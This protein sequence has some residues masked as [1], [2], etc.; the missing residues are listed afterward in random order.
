MRTVFREKS[1]EENHQKRKEKDRMSLSLQPYWLSIPSTN[2]GYGKPPEVKRSDKA[3]IPVEATWW[4]SATVVRWPRIKIS[5][6]K[7]REWNLVD[8]P[9]PE[10]QGV[11][12]PNFMCRFLTIF[13]NNLRIIHTWSWRHRSSR[14]TSG[15]C[16]IIVTHFLCGAVCGSNTSPNSGWWREPPPLLGCV[17]VW[18]SKVFVFKR[19]FEEW[20]ASPNVGMELV[21][22]KLICCIS[23]VP[24]IS[25]LAILIRQGKSSK[26]AHSG[27]PE[28]WIGLFLGITILFNGKP[29]ISRK[30]PAF[31]WSPQIA[32]LG[33]TYAHRV[34]V[35]HKFHSANIHRNLRGERLRDST[36]NR[37]LS[38]CYTI[39]HNHAS[40]IYYECPHLSVKT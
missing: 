33:S 39:E 16:K 27:I 25:T 12:K 30:F 26:N 21:W 24:N 20:P 1:G 37:W 28:C 36:H 31:R 2:S 19:S 23:P 5:A 13:P 10:V 17:C 7:R 34:S 29:W 11:T 22:P 35:F 8:S 15:P 14:S 38:R 40:L 18:F 4:A 6:F 3:E 9:Q 32:F